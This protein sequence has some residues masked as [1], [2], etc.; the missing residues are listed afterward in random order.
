MKCHK[1][2]VLKKVEQR[3]GCLSL[4]LEVTVKTVLIHRIIGAPGEVGLQ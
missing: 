4:G 3:L 2:Q 1:H